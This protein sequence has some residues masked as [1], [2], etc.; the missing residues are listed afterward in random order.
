MQVD[1]AIGKRRQQRLVHHAH[2]AG[3]DHILAAALEQLMRNDL[4]S[5]DGIGID[6]LGQCE[7]LDARTL[8]T[9]QAP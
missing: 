2:I 4:V 7:R 1:H 8:G 9:L 3:H 6:I 5:G